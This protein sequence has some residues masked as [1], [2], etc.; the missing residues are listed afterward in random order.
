MRTITDDEQTEQPTM[1][2]CLEKVCELT[3]AVDIMGE[4]LDRLIKDCSVSKEHILGHVLLME[5]Q[6]GKLMQAA[7]TF[8]HAYILYTDREA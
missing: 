6:A 7:I 2:L 4:E 1:L 5:N 8:R 3:F